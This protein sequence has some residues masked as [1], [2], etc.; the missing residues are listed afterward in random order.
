MHPCGVVLSNT[1]LLDRLPVQADTDDVEDLGL[2]KL[3]VLG[4]RMQSAAAH[5][6]T[7]SAPPPA[8]QS[9]STTGSRSPSSRPRTRWGCSSWSP[10]PAGSGRPPPARDPQDVIADISLFRP[11]PVQ[12]AV[13][14]LYITARR[15]AAPTYPHPDLEP[16]LRDTYEVTIWHFTD[17][18][19]SRIA[20]ELQRCVAQVSARSTSVGSVGLQDM[21]VRCRAEGDRRGG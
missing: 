15:G 5:A 14:A 12:G 4:V 7:K 1:S 2:L 10:R 16:V 8:R 3:D 11:G 20:C 6:V 17:H 18:R 13:P 21:S 19:N 9:T